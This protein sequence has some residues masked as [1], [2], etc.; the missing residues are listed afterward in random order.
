MTLDIGFVYLCTVIATVGGIY[1][2]VTNAKTI[3]HVGFQS[4][5]MAVSTDGNITNKV[6]NRSKN[7]CVY[8]ISTFVHDMDY[9]SSASFD[10]F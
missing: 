3:L 7:D 4:F 8:S 9:E 2:Y 5:C 10:L 1:N 6:I